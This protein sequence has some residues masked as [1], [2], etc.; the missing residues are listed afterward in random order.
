MATAATVVTLLS[1]TIDIA[2]V[3]DA[4]NEADMQS[5][6]ATQE[7]VEMV[8]CEL[9]KCMPTRRWQM[10]MMMQARPRHGGL[11]SSQV[12]DVVD[13]ITLIQTRHHQT[14]KTHNGEIGSPASPQSH[15]SPVTPGSCAVT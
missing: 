4:T 8:T 1:V 11:V 5:R 10:A 9:V 15:S 12:V 2:A 13:A 14:K 7:P 6:M 3:F